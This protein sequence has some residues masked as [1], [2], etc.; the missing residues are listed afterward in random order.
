MAEVG[1][2][3]RGDP[4]DVHPAPRCR[5]RS[6]RAAPDAC[7]AGAPAGRARAG[8]GTA[9]AA[10]QASHAPRAERL[11][12]P[13]TRSERRPRD[14]RA[15]A[16][17]GADGAV[18]T[19]PRD[20]GP[21]ARAPGSG[22]RRS[23]SARGPVPASSL[24]TPAGRSRSRSV[25]R[26]GRPRSRSSTSPARSSGVAGPAPEH[27]AQ[28][29]LDVEGQPVVDAVHVARRRAPARD[30]PCGRCCSST[31][32]NTAIRRRR[33]VVGVHQHHRPAVA[34]L[35]VQHLE[36]ARRHLAGGDDVDSPAPGSPRLD[37]RPAPARPVVTHH[38]TLPGP[39][40][41]SRSTVGGTTPPAVARG[42][43][44]GGHL[45]PRPACRPGSPTAAAPP[46]PACRRSRCRRR[47][48]ATVA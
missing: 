14:D 47:P 25:R 8:A 36:P 13:R 9:A 33:R 48:G 1:G 30:R 44:V 21:A 11:S 45:A 32:S 18:R 34:A 40:G 41:P 22:P 17:P 16:S 20:G 10:G 2:V 19:R 46:P 23:R 7:R 3:V 29:V 31:T 27:G 39:N 4:A 43:H 35:G 24:R 26:P 28:L 37:R 42:H 38:C 15:V 12:R 5:R 6:A